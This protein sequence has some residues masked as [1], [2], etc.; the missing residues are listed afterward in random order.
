MN[1]RK[2]FYRLFL[3]FFLVF[4]IC[5]N[6][7]SGHLAFTKYTQASGL[8]SNYIFDIFQ[9][10]DGFLWI[11]TDRGISRFDG[12]TF[13]NFTRTEG[14]SANQVY[15]IFQ[16]RTG[17]MWF[18]T[19]EGGVAR[20][21]GH[22]IL[23]ISEADGLLD[24]TVLHITQDKFGRMYFMTEKGLSVYQDRVLVSYKNRD[25][26]SGNLFL[27]DSGKIFF[28]LDDSLFVITPQENLPLKVKPIKLSRSQG[29]AISMRSWAS[30]VVSDEN[31]LYYPGRNQCLKIGL[32]DAGE[33]LDIGIINEAYFAML[34]NHKNQLW[35]ARKHGIL[36]SDNEKIETMTRDAGLEPDYIEALLED[37]EGNTWLGT[38]GGGLYK[39]KGDHL[40]YYMTQDG[41]VSNFVNTVIE[42]A[43][44]NALA[45]TMQGLCRISS[46][47]EIENIRLQPYTREVISIHQNQRGQFY[48]GTFTELLGPFDNHFRIDNP[49]D[50]VKYISAGVSS[51]Y[52]EDNGAVWVS[53]FGDGA[54]C[55]RDSTQTVWTKADGLP[56]NVID[57][58]VPG[59]NSLWFL[60]RE[61]GAA[62]LKD[63]SVEI[64]DRA[65][66]L[67]S[68]AVYS[69]LEED[70]VLW[71]GT[72]KGLTRI[73]HARI[74][75]Y[76]KAEGLI[77]K[78]VLGIFKYLNRYL[79][80]TDK[81]L[82]FLENDRIEVCAGSAI[83]PSGEVTI[84][85]VFF[86]GK[87]GYL[88][89]ATS[90]GVVKVDIEKVV[91][92]R[93]WLETRFPNILIT[94]VCC[95]TSCLYKYF[96]SGENLKLGEIELNPSQNN[97][98]FNFTGISF[99]SETPLHYTYRLEGNDADWCEATTKDEVSYLNLTSGIYTFYVK[100]I[101]SAGTPSQQA[102]VFSFKINPPFWRQ[103]W[104]LIPVSVSGIALL[105]MSGFFISSY[106]NRKKFRQLEQERILQEE[107]QKTREH[108]AAELHDDVSSTLSSINLL[109]ETLKNRQKHEPEKTD[110][111]L[112]KLNE[113]THEAQETMEEVVWSLS[114]HHDT[115]Q[116]LILRICDFVCE[117][118]SNHN[119]VCKTEILESNQ[120]FT[121]E[122]LTRKSIYLIA[123]E[124]MHNIV[125]HAKASQVHLRIGL[126][127]QDFI[128]E[129]TDNGTGFVE[130]IKTNRFKGG[131]GL[132][133]M[134]SRALEIN[135]DFDLWSEP[136]R[137]T[138][139]SLKKKI[140]QMSY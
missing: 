56:A 6:L 76:S 126:L 73:E 44:G 138:R 69:M 112:G 113:L 53:T 43:S 71:F 101:N 66:G 130:A 132:H 28:N 98:R 20:Y 17:D 110:L 116:Q 74:K 128:L 8:A 140:A 7:I 88:W 89:L 61:Y 49:K 129:F 114:P 65:D 46:E 90:S 55:L 47:G 40:A 137:G 104:F 134:R 51:I 72:D 34:K 39:Y 79:I 77:G 57:E 63:N 81:A 80:V 127:E 75:N 64:F 2:L 48:A 103:M 121:V 36:I 96:A 106:S 27:H 120:D 78:N 100:A 52:S 1:H 95:D 131:H 99:L 136:D 9:D 67:P 5:R 54:L 115:I 37:H 107:R 15:C 26:L 93:K 16:D 119:L 30:P 70:S 19:Y 58:I 124:A 84:K 86:S 82:H 118:C 42:D 123:K 24:N 22:F 12:Q 31:M 62:R 32:N 85:Q 18:G 139:L 3:V 50:Q 33:I 41:L 135:A 23:A 105:I 25:N 13:R 10:R 97:I 109:T 38:M 35:F 29:K 14:L 94:E 108:I 111:I 4:F 125:K 87:T 45:G 21:N 133:N 68:L 59:K 102:A 117:Y 11:A 122:E 83:L 91:A 92:R 60:S